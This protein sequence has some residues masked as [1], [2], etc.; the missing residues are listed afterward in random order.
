MAPDRVRIKISLRRRDEIRDWRTGVPRYRLGHQEMPLVSG[1]L[2][3]V[4]RRNR[5]PPAP[6]H[7]EPL[8]V[9]ADRQRALLEVQ[10][11]PLKLQLQ[12]CLEERQ[13]PRHPRCAL[14]SPCAR[15]D[16]R[17]GQL[18]RG[19]HKGAHDQCREDRSSRAG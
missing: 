9:R 11:G 6:A 4:H 16:E 15:P 10:D 2:A 8:H 3:Q 13:R 17:G 18:L 7:P 19:G 12:S 1:R 5:P 14:A